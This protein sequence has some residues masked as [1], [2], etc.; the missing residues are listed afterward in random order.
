MTRIAELKDRVHSLGLVME[1][2]SSSRGPWTFRFWALG[3]PEPIGKVRGRAK[4]KVWLS[5]YEAGV[6]LKE[7]GSD[8]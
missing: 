3:F 2:D 5:G 1:V 4:A 6:Q 8:G 7:V